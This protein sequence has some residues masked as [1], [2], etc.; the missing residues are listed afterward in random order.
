MVIAKF[1]GNEL[2]ADCHASR[3]LWAS[4][5]FGVFL[6]SECA[7][8]HRGL[9]VHISQVRSVTLDDWTP[10]QVFSVLVN[11]NQYV[12]SYLL[13]HQQGKRIIHGHDSSFKNRFIS[14]KYD[15]MRY[16]NREGLLIVS[17]DTFPQ[18]SVNTVIDYYR[19]AIGE[20]VSSLSIETESIPFVSARQS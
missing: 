6:C 20:Y 14:D 4:V 13:K 19:H 18:L 5:N 7:G 9:G 2:C 3:S 10:S 12:N 16:G 8:I 17:R 1:S 11:G 15:K